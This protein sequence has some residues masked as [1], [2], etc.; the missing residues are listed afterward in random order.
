MRELTT[1]ESQS[2]AGAAFIEGFITDD[3]AIYGAAIG[4]I[5]SYVLGDIAAI[6]Y[7]DNPSISWADKM[8]CT[9]WTA[10]EGAKYGLVLD[11]AWIASDYLLRRN[12]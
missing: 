2:V 12:G 3:F 6:R 8:R 7:N 10:I 5:G 1:Y 9:F 11:A 4:L